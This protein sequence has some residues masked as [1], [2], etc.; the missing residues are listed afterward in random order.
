M[1]YGIVNVP[2][3][4]GS[5]E[6]V[7]TLETQVSQLK[8]EVAGKAASADLTAHTKNR[9]NPHG[10]TAE[11]VGAALKEHTHDKIVF[12]DD[13]NDE[14]TPENTTS[15]I[16]VH[17]KNNGA[18]GLNNGGSLH[19]VV[20][21]RSWHDMTGPKIHEL[22]F[23]DNG[24][25]AHRYST[26]DGTW[27][28]WSYLAHQYDL[29]KIVED[30]QTYD[31]NTLT[32]G[33]RAYKCKGDSSNLPVSGAFG[34]LLVMQASSESAFA[35]QLYFCE[36]DNSG[37]WKRYQ[38]GGNWQAWV[39]VIDTKNIGSQSVNNATYAA[40]GNYDQDYG[41]RLRNQA[42]VAADTTPGAN[43]QIFWTYG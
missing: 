13:R 15:G 17:I 43:G 10:V 27:S 8:T 12:M 3:G 2:G 31:L 38:A 42:L 28:E 18:D 22:G 5:E 6:K 39:R 7:Q 14:V 37:I 4:G 19:S 16:T 41:A 21:V 26:G 34:H 40:I 29:N 32:E 35:I 9:N 25:L 23:T 33:F 1:G 30:Y 36:D 20:T 24:I 11:Q